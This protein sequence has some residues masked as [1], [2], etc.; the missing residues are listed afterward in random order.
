MS[1]LD[2]DKD[3]FNKINNLFD[4]VQMDLEQHVQPVIAESPRSKSS[5][6]KRNSKEKLSPYGDSISSLSKLESLCTHSKKGESTFPL[7]DR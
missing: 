6:S 4:R 7:T 3:K 5:G 1:N 2:L